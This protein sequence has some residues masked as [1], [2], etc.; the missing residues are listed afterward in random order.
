[1]GDQRQYRHLPGTNPKIIQ[2]ALGAGKAIV[3]A[4]VKWQVGPAHAY[5]MVRAN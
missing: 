1:M 4:V 5:A 3:E 2:D